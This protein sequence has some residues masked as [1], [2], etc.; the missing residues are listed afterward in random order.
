MG[1]FVNFIPSTDT[2]WESVCVNVNSQNLKI[3][4]GRTVL[5]DVE[6]AM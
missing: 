3:R 6:E 2:A 5:A 1:D 4:V